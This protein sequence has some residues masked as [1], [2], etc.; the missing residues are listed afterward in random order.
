VK[1]EVDT[2]YLS[3]DPKTIPM[4]GGDGLFIQCTVTD[5]P[6]SAGRS[7]DLYVDRELV[8]K[9]MKEL[10]ANAIAARAQPMEGTG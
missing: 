3:G 4:P 8:P 2:W 10:R 7:I 9:L 6:S 1:A 5:P